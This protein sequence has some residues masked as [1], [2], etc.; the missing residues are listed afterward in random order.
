[1][2][3]IKLRSHSVYTKNHQITDR[4]FNNG[5]YIADHEMAIMHSFFAWHIAVH[6]P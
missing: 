6:N 1:M 2:H 5:T 3:E 4:N